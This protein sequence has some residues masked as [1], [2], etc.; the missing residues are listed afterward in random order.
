[1]RVGNVVAAASDVARVAVVV[2]VVGSFSGVPRVVLVTLPTFEPA[3]DAGIPI[4]VSASNCSSCFIS[5]EML[6]GRRGEREP[7]Q[8]AS[9]EKMWP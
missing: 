9:V 7:G 6:A 2:A 5:C 8:W 3:C 4:T 1:M